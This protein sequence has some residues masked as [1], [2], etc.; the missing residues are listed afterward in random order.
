MTRRY[1][2]YNH[3]VTSLVDRTRPRTNQTTTAGYRGS[4][5]Q[6]NPH[7]RSDSHVSSALSC[8]H[9][10][11]SASP[12]SWASLITFNASSTCSKWA[13]ANVSRRVPE[14]ARASV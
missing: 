11:T 8:A 9:S 3:F 6:I 13:P 10:Q 2:I 12:C 1:M 7:N 14:Q 4:I 5:V